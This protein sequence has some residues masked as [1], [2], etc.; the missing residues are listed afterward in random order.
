VL[1]LAIIA[2]G[3]TAIPLVRVGERN[4]FATTLDSAPVADAAAIRDAVDYLPRE[5]RFDAFVAL[6]DG[7]LLAQW[8]DVDVPI[9]THSVRK[10]LLS[11]LY[12]IAI[13]KGLIRLDA[14]LADLGIDDAKA[15]LTMIEKSATVRDL[16]M[17]RSGIYIEAAGEVQGM[18]DRRPRRGSKKPGE[19]FYYN[20]WDFNVLGVIFERQ[21]KL[22]I[23]QALSAWIAQ[24]VGMTQFKPGNVVYDQP[25]YSEHRQFIVYMTASDLARFGMLYANGGRWRDRQ[26]V[27]QAWVDESTRAYSDVVDMKPFDAYGYLWWI[28][29]DDDVIWADGWGG[30]FLIVDAKRHLALVSR[31]D[32]G[33]S[34]LQLGLFVLFD[35]DGWRSHHQRLHH[36]MIRA[37]G[38]TPA[39]TRAPAVTGGSGVA[40]LAPLE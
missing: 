24:P 15:P 4:A 36:L 39:E 13:D 31:N 22:T 28:D 37:T 40:L 3:V 20:N 29:R 7:A 21:T 8:G 16:L 1:A 18:K 25:G 38:E 5:T 33:R 34:L 10:S 2:V 14:T 23:G 26:V 35:K 12:G 30:Q 19:F 27:P 9:N 32:T 17:A 11:A 6:K